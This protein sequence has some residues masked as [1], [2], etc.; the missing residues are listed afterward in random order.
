MKK[1]CLILISIFYFNFSSAEEISGF[2]N[3]IDGDTI[4]IGEKK[5]RLYGIDAPEKQQNCFKNWISFGFIQFS[6]EYNCGKT[7]K[8]KLENYILNKK[9]KCIS[10]SKDRYGRF[11]GICYLGNNDIN[12]WLVRNGYALAYK[13]YSRKYEIQEKIAKEQKLG[14]WRGNFDMPWEWRKK[15]K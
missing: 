2:A 4:R 13:R 5:I 9:I 6:K 14:L 11:L 7:S 12:K 3:I 8:I 15:N 1:L 10:E